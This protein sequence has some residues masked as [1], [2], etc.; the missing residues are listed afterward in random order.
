MCSSLRRLEG[1]ARGS[2]MYTTSNDGW[3]R[4]STGCRRPG[5]QNE[6]RA[7]HPPKGGGKKKPENLKH[8]YVTAHGAAHP[9]IHQ[10]FITHPLS[11][12]LPADLRCGRGTV[13]PAGGC[14]T[15]TRP[16][17]AHNCCAPAPRG[18]GPGRAA[19]AS[20]RA[21]CEASVARLCWLQ[22]PTAPTTPLL[23]HIPSDRGGS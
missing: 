11:T 8:R 14:T 16:G 17:T 10:L 21:Q 18:R 7:Y 13:W 22:H 20:P 15:A 4:T 23:S 6:C 12:G 5:L 9:H 19:A 1:W 2:L 3:T